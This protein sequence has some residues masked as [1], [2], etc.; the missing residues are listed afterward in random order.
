MATGRQ[1]DRATGRVRR[2]IQMNMQLKA[3]IRAKATINKYGHNGL[4]D[5][6]EDITKFNAK[7]FEK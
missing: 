4:A 5:A 2:V 1:G 6:I 7:V 3:M